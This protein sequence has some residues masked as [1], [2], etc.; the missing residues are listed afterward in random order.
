MKKT[1]ERWIRSAAALLAIG[2]MVGASTTA[3]AQYCA[4]IY[5]EGSFERRKGLSL[6]AG[7]VVEPLP[8]RV[9]NINVEGSCAIT[10]GVRG[11]VRTFTRA[12]YGAWSRDWLPG[13]RRS[14]ASCECPGAQ[15][16]RGKRKG[17]REDRAVA[18]PPVE[19]S[20]PPRLSRRAAACIAWNGERFDGDWIAF[21]R[22]ESE[23]L[24]RRDR[25]RSI[26]VADGCRAVLTLKDRPFRVVVDEPMGQ[27]PQFIRRNAQSL[28][29][30]CGR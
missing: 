24:P 18:P 17:K 13:G 9:K 6:Q 14:F 8:F 22:G 30:R 19:D 25:M 5:G 2:V 21:R 1:L 20:R 28:D 11:D 16:Q 27:L 26:E 7:D 3:S 4:S 15:E 10:I 23:Q 29:C 12:D